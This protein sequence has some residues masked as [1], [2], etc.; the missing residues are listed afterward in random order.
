M[1]IGSRQKMFLNKEI[2]MKKEKKM[3]RDD[4]LIAIGHPDQLS[5][6]KGIYT[7]RWGYFYRHG[8]TSDECVQSV[9]DG[10]S[11]VRVIDSGDVWKSFRGGASVKNQSH[12]FVKFQ[13]AQ[14][15]NIFTVS[16]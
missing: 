13:I 6:S 9:L 3:S 14:D 15:R 7:A 1:F 16:Q 11:G 4:I 8:R 2:Q 10:L 5:K 12:F